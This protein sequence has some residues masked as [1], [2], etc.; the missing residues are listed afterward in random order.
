MKESCVLKAV[1]K[2]P[3]Q[4]SEEDGAEDRGY[5]GRYL[6]D[7]S[8]QLAQGAGVVPSDRVTEEEE[9]CSLPV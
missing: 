6:L 7:R 9:P 8:N 3:E 5:I 4:L 2:P 1:S